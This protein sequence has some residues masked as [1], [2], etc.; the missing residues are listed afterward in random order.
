MS[1][2]VDIHATTQKNRQKEYKDKQMALIEVKNL[3][4]V[5]ST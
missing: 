4:L 5:R 1:K 3:V 2:L